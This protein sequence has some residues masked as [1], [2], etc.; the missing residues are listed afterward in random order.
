MS[1]AI[2]ISFIAVV[3]VRRARLSIRHSLDVGVHRQLIADVLNQSETLELNDI[4]EIF[5]RSHVASTSSWVSAT[6]PEQT[7]SNAVS[8]QNHSGDVVQ[9]ESRRGEGADVAT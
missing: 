2:C 9:M 1:S 3:L 7:L 4:A 6:D 8:D 5:R